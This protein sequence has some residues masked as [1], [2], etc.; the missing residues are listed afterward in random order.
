[1]PRES[2]IEQYLCKQCQARGGI[3]MKWSSPGHRGV[4]D[5]IVLMPGARIVFVELKAPGKRPGPLQEREHR[6]LRKL[7]F[8]VHV[9][10]SY[11]GVD[12][13]MESL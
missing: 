4:P 8:D 12:K 3:A 9:I 7:G 1:M 10:D 5:R 13:L 6:R 2:H 11:I